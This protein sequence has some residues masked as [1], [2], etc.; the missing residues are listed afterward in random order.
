MNYR[1]RIRGDIRIEER[2]AWYCKVKLQYI[3][4]SRDTGNRSFR[5]IYVRSILKQ[6]IR[7]II[8]H[9][10]FLYFASEPV[11]SANSRRAHSPDYWHSPMR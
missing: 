10:F 7:P 4:E 8:I 6:F 3:R 5:R 2:L 11:E 1:E 9:L